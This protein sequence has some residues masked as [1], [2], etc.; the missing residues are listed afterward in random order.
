MRHIP[1]IVHKSI[2]KYSSSKVSSTLIL[3]SLGVA[4]DKVEQRCNS[5][6]KTPVD[7]LLRYTR[8]GTRCALGNAAGDE[9]S[10]EL[11]RAEIQTCSQRGSWEDVDTPLTINGQYFLP[12]RAVDGDIAWFRVAT[13]FSG[14]ANASEFVTVAI[15]VI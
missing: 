6:D 10:E 12:Y 11:D 14:R 2:V 5:R 3:G 13:L 15:M 9:V 7:F 1:H 4:T 8:A